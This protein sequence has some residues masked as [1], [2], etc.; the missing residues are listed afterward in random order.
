MKLYKIFVINPGS[1]STKVELFENEKS[2]LE[3]NVFHANLYPEHRLFSDETMM[4]L[5]PFEVALADF[6]TIMM[7]HLPEDSYAENC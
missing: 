1:T 5:H 3:G 7:K 4:T 2:I 6:V